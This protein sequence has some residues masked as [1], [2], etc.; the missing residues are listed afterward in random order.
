MMLAR[1][2]FVLE[3]NTCLLQDHG[4]SYT[5]TVLRIIDANDYSLLDF[6]MAQNLSLNIK[7]RYLVPAR[8]DDWWKRIS[9]VSSSSGAQVLTIDRFAPFKKIDIAH[10]LCNVAGLEKALRS[11]GI[12]GA[13][14]VINVSGSRGV[15]YYI[16][17]VGQAVLGKHERCSDEDLA[18]VSIFQI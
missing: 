4:G 5:L 13:F 6:W 14:Y 18:L 11:Q 16:L 12:L 8:F 9:S 7:R 15:S 2:T 3:H 10:L 17:P 1:V